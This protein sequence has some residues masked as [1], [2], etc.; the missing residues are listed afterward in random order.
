MVKKIIILLIFI[1]FLGYTQENSVVIKKGLLRAQGI[2]SFG[3]FTDLKETSIFLHGTTEYYTSK[4]ITVRCDLFYY[5]TPNTESTIAQNH[6]MFAGGS[7]HFNVNGKF[8][9]YIG[10]QPGLTLSQ[11]NKPENTTIFL[12]EAYTSY[13]ITL[14]PLISGVI[15]FNYYASKWF[16]LFIDGR[17]VSGQHLSDLP[18]I[19]LNEIR[20]S[21]GLG[22]NLNILSKK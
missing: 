4:N 9:P 12:Q 16:H 10:I 17:Y 14:N 13:P 15:G 18:P 20:L 3:H 6:Q 11:K 5:L 2:I 21:F 22:F 19:S 1:P 7:Y 8:D